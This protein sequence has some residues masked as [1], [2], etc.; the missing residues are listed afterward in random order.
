LGRDISPSSHNEAHGLLPR[1]PERNLTMPS[2]EKTIS[3]RAYLE[4]RTEDGET[5]F[6]SINRILESPNLQRKCIE[7]KTLQ[8]IIAKL[9][10]HNALD[11]HTLQ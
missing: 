6:V 10:K 7:Q 3:Y 2:K 1:H 4:I 9:R 5:G 8:R 11:E